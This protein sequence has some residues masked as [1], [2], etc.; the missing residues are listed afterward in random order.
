VGAALLERGEAAYAWL[1]AIAALWMICVGLLVG[2]LIGDAVG[3]GDPG[4]TSALGS[5]VRVVVSLSVYA[6]LLLPALALARAL[7]SATVGDVTIDSARRSEMLAQSRAAH[8]FLFFVAGVVAVNAYGWAWARN[9]VSANWLSAVAQPG[10]PVATGAEPLGL[11][12]VVFGA[13]VLHYL[14]LIELP[15]WWGQRTWKAG[16][17]E[18]A[19]KQLREVEDA[20]AQ[21][22]KQP[23]GPAAASQLPRL[24]AQ[25]MIAQEKVRAAKEAPV[26]TFRSA[27]DL[28]R[29]LATK[30]GTAVL[31]VAVGGKQVSE[32]AQGPL[33]GL[34]EWVGGLPFAGP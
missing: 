7:S 13:M 8:W 17:L 19:R 18:Q 10:S 30:L 14:L 16:Q 12:V 34:V 33:S 29:K 11:V 9:L 15:Y 22:L 31:A 24:L 32:L 20:L 3:A 23:E 2:L 1:P 21:A 4:P 27:V 28:G 6:L 5:A 25:H 26:H